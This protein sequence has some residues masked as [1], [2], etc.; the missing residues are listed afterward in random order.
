[1]KNIRPMMFVPAAATAAA[2]A[3]TLAL[4]VTAL[5]AHAQDKTT[6]AL[7]ADPAKPAMAAPAKSPPTTAKPRAAAH[8]AYDRQLN[9]IR[10]RGEL[11]VGMSPFLPW[12]FPD[13]KVG[14]LGFD[15]DIARQLAADLGVTLRIVEI[16]FPRLLEAV[17]NGDVDIVP[18]ISITP[19]R[20]LSVAF[21]QPYSHSQLQLV[22]RTQD[23]SRSNWNA[24][25]VTIGVREGSLSELA[26]AERFPEAKVV[27]FDRDARMFD[28]LDRGTINAALAFSPQPQIRIAITPGS[29]A[30]VQAAQLSRTAEGFAV[31][32]G[33]PSLV[34]FLNAWITYWQAEGWLEKLH[35]EWFD[36]LGWTARLSPP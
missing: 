26:A 31:R 23:A 3:L 30:I 36:T 17:R 33:E 19:Q 28:A 20:A 14:W 7:A 24:A 22:A 35:A 27:T 6:P 21:S 32:K 5:P 12:E 9:D 10:R 2:F 25:D 16:P 34:N 11:V 13:P 4:A 18:S 15:V 1:M 8:H 29:V